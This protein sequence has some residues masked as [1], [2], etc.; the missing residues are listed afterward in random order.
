M[1]YSSLAGWEPHPD[2]KGWLHWPGRDYPGWLR[3]VEG[4]WYSEADVREGKV[5]MTET[6][7][8]RAPG[9]YV[10]SSYPFR[11]VPEPEPVQESDD[12]D[13]IKR[14]Q[15]ALHRRARGER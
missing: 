12:D 11:W 2:L 9:W 6:G 1:R 4:G 14:F 5:V 15:D 7:P 10:E 13:V 8:E 3:S